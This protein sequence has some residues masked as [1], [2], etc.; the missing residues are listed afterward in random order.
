[1]QIE[2][3]SQQSLAIFDSIDFDGSGEIS[4]PEF[5]SD[6]KMVCASSMEELIRENHQKA[7]DN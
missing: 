7:Q 3:T 5:V 1:M 2:V 6:F 4:L